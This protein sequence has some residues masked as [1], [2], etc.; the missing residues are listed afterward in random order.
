MTGLWIAIGAGILLAGGMWA[1]GGYFVRPHP[2][3]E[4]ALRLLDGQGQ[5]PAAAARGCRPAAGQSP[6]AK[7]GWACRRR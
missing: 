6:A 3:L 4:D 2:R 5:E 1:L 7:T